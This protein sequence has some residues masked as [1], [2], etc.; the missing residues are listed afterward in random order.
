MRRGDDRTGRL[1]AGCEQAGQYCPLVESSPQESGILRTD[2][3]QSPVSRT[4]RTTNGNVG[5]AARTLI[6]GSN[7]WGAL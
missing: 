5:Y 3:I 7:H 2:P 1:V 6:H 4:C